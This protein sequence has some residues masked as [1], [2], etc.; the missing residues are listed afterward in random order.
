MI[1]FAINLE[2]EIEQSSMECNL[3]SVMKAIVERHGRINDAMGP[4]RVNLQVDRPSEN[5]DGKKKGG[6][7][8]MANPAAMK[9]RCLVCQL[10][11]DVNDCGHV[12][13]ALKMQARQRGELLPGKSEKESKG[14]GT[15]ARQAAD[16]EEDQCEQ[17]CVVCLRIFPERQQR[18]KTHNTQECWH[19][20]KIV[21]QREEGGQTDN[22]NRYR[23]DNPNYQKQNQERF[24]A[25][26]SHYSPRSMQ[27]PSF[28]T[29]PN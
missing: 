10:E 17:G 5:A 1:E 12:K 8:A 22:P 9:L 13:E 14:R 15:K 25:D 2:Q 20:D 4:I 6:K 26:Q 7:P 21:K 19:I 23:R 18:A 29:G 24:F 3:E 11:H 16:P 28:E 27:N